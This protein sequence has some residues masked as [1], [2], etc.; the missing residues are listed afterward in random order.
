MAAYSAIYDTYADDKLT[1][2]RQRGGKLLLIHGMSDPIF[3]AKDTVDYY[4]RL[5]AN[6]GGMASTQGFA[7]TFLVPGMNHCSGGPATDSFD[8]IQ[9]MVDWVEKGVAPDTIAARALPTQAD[10]PNRTRPLCP[11][12]QFAKYKGTGSV[13]DAGSFVCSEQ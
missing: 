4:E 8:S 1:A 10:Y 9:T 5:A 7:R 11:Y 12:P 2:F 6:N 3:S 13:E